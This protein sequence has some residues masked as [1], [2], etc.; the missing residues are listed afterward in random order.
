M[1]IQ[2]YSNYI[3]RYLIINIILIFIIKINSFSVHLI[4]LV[5]LINTFTVMEENYEDDDGDNFN[6]P[7]RDVVKSQIKRFINL[8]NPKRGKVVP[9]P[10]VAVAANLKLKSLSSNESSDYNSSDKISNLSPTDK[11]NELHMISLA[12]LVVYFVT[13]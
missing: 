10:E 9:V 5:K 12:T 6:N 7:I 13:I 1:I 3:Y 8:K 2:Y 11:E 4:L